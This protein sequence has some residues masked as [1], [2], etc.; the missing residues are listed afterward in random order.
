MVSFISWE[1]ECAW[2][3]FTWERIEKNRKNLIRCWFWSEVKYRSIFQ[4]RDQFSYPHWFDKSNFF[5][6][7]GVSSINLRSICRWCNNMTDPFECGILVRRKNAI[8]FQFSLHQRC[9]VWADGKEKPSQCMLFRNSINPINHDIV[10]LV[11]IP[12]SQYVAYD[13]L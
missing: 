1:M 13:H 2:I 5:S 3:P 10:C 9:S 8:D 11:V 12:Y 7:R 4:K 6:F